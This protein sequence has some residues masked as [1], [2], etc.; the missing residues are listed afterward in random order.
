MVINNFSF[1][2]FFLQTIIINTELQIKFTKYKSLNS[3]QL[4]FS[5]E[6]FV[7]YFIE[8]VYVSEISLGDPPQKIPSFLNPVQSAFY[9][10]NNDYLCPI[11]TY[12]LYNNSSS[13]KPIEEANLK[14][15]VLNRFYD[16]LFLDKANNTEEEEEKYKVNN[17]E[18]FANCELKNAVCFIVGTKLNALG[19]QIEDNLLYRLHTNKYIKSY[20][21][22]FDLNPRNNEELIYAFD[23]DISPDDYTIIKTSFYEADHRKYLVWGLDFNK[24][25]FDDVI[26]IG[27]QLRAE[28]KFDLGCVIAPLC[29]QDKFENFLKKNGVRANIVKHNNKYYI[30]SFNKNDYEYEKLENFSLTFNHKEL[31]YNF[32][33]NYKD[34]FYELNNKI[35]SLIVFE[36]KDSDY[37]KLGLPFLKKFKFIY[38]QDS[39]V[40]GFRKEKINASK[41]VTGNN[42]EDPKVNYLQIKSKIIIIVALIFFMVLVAMVFFGILIGKKMYKVRK[43]K[44][45]ELLE[46]YDYNSNKNNQ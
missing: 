33:L 44:V 17:Y 10:T 38:N 41:N 4:S 19:E 11:K 34:V 29:F 20:Y 13:Y 3:E 42:S 21:F 9:L 35:F 37:W 23:L 18:L 7:K 31:K 12:Y 40:V 30:Y 22:T 2:I 28:F 5:T 15:S 24:I 27:Y 45:N 32:V 14:Y 16:T 26:L 6:L 46:L 8:N 43:N 25:L 1:L 36:T 39:K